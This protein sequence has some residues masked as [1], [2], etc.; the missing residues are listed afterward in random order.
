MGT[1]FLIDLMVVFVVNLFVVLLLCVSSSL[2]RLTLS[3]SILMS[4]SR[5]GE[6]L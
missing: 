6:Q 5:V 2:V 1:V 3:I 4:K